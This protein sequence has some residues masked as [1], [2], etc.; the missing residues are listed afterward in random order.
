M[1]TLLLLKLFGTTTP[2]Y[3]VNV[4]AYR[5]AKYTQDQIDWAKDCAAQNNVRYRIVWK[6][7]RR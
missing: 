7:R 5:L 2:A 6:K 1:C 3:V 4:P